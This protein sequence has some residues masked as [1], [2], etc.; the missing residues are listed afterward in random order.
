MGNDTI[1]NMITSIR[2]A[3]LGKI[4]T[5]QVPATNA[6]RDI[7]KILLREGFIEDSIDDNENKKNVLVSNPKYQGR[8]K[9][10]YI[11]TLRRISKSGL[12]IY[13]NHKEIPK[14]LG[15]MGIVILSTSGGIMTDRE[16]RQKKIGGEL[17]CYVW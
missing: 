14:V 9:K 7:A 10:S 13:S 17:L 2:N 5:V 11:T 8:K 16:A 1:A 6:T 3:N 4:K 12:R 15:G